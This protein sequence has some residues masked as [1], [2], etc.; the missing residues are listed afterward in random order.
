MHR[1]EA[2]VLPA[3]IGFPGYLPASSGVGPAAPQWRPP[4]MSSEG[5]LASEAG[6]AMQP[7]PWLG[8]PFAGP[9]TAPPLKPTH[10]VMSPSRLRLHCS[11]SSCISPPLYRKARSTEEDW[12]CVL[13]VGAHHNRLASRSSI[14]K[15]SITHQCPCLKTTEN[16]LFYRG[17]SAGDG[18]V[19]PGASCL[20]A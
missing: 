4:A 5:P 20:L 19:W 17:I 2:T 7:F 6:P 15:K 16:N 12:C 18:T 3:G 8:A 9:G 14:G 10:P 1:A 13:P 11:A